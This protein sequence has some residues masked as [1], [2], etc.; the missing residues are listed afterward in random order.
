MITKF[1]KKNLI[2]LRADLDAALA[3]IG[4]KHGL[5]IHTGSCS[6][7]EAAATFKLK[8]D[9]AD[10]RIQQAKAR[11]DFNYSC[12]FY[13]L[14]PEHYG[15][16]VSLNGM[17]KK[18]VGIVR[19]RAKYPLKFEGTDGK[20]MLYTVDIVPKILQAYAAQSKTGAA[21]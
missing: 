8:C 21:A 2:A 6:Y 16:T 5:K 3:A 4:E 20:T 18:L 1:D 9:V 14:K 19:T 17:P 11:E 7:D 13:G 10:P 15:V 12:L